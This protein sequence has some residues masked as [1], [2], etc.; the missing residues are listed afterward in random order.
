LLSIDR[1]NLPVGEAIGTVEPTNWDDPVSVEEPELEP[2]PLEYLPDALREWVSAAAEAFQVP[3]DL[4]GLLALAAC[5]GMVARRIEV[6]LSPEW[7]EPVN[8][9]VCCLLEPANRKSAAFR[10]AFGPVREIERRLIESAAPEIAKMQAERRIDEKRL[11]ELERK[12]SK[13]NREAIEEARQVAVKLA[14]T[15]VPALP[16]LIMDDA[17]AEA[18]EI[19]LAVQG[20]RLIVAGPEG[21]VFDVMAGRYSGGASNLDVFLKGHAGDDLRVDRVTRGAVFVERVCLTLAYAV[22]PEVIRGL[23]ANRAFRGRGL[24]GR[25]LY[26]YPANILGRRR[27]D[28]LPIPPGVADGY[29]RLIARLHSLGESVEENPRRLTFSPGAASCFRLWRME[30][31]SWLGDSGRLADLRDWGGKLCGLTAR[32]AGLFHLIDC[33]FDPLG[34]PIGQDSIARAIGLARWSVGHAEAVVSLMG[35]DCEPLSDAAYV[36]RWLRARG[37][38]DVTRRDIHSHGRSRF[39]KEPDRLD[40]CL[41]VLMDRGWL[42]GIESADKGP[43]RPSVRFEVNPRAFGPESKLNPMEGLVLESSGGRV[44]GVI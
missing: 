21:G 34:T 27:I 36:L 29:G 11:A 24:I 4:P 22:Q 14:E 10:A 2:L 6:A 23:A 37:L 44:R 31:E 28:S 8:L 17:T 25:F 13:G 3:S 9:F 41:M 35:S 16:R 30:V 7:I 43:G 12:G 20:G 26:C 19:A 38:P 32:L 15:P 1:E 5:S 33:Q 18:V 39:D 40:R 42:R